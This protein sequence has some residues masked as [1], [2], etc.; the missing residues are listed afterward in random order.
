MINE[1]PEFDW[2]V[3]LGYNI[4]SRTKAALKYTHGFKEQGIGNLNNNNNNYGQEFR[5][6]TITFNLSYSLFGVKH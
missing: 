6:R 4:N 3:G 5:N 1:K 2:I